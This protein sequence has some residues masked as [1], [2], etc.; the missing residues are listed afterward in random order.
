MSG[1]KFQLNYCG[2]PSVL[3]A[4]YRRMICDIPGDRLPI[5]EVVDK[6]GEVAYLKMAWPAQ[7]REAIERYLQRNNIVV[8]GPLWTH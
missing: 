8:D 1:D 2:D 4:L 5:I 6:R 3:W 7:F